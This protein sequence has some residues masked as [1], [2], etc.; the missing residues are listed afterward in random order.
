MISLNTDNTCTQHGVRAGEGAECIVRG[1]VTGRTERVDPGKAAESD[2]ATIAALIAQCDS[3]A[4]MGDRHKALDLLIRTAQ[5]LT[6]ATSA[7][8]AWLQDGK[9]MCLGRCGETAPDLGAQLDV[10]SGLS[11]ECVQTGRL[12]RCDDAVADPRVHSGFHR[13]LGLKSVL[14]LPLI[15]EGKVKGVVEVF[16]PEPKAFGEAE[17]IAL[18]LLTDLMV[19][20]LSGQ[21]GER[22]PV[23]SAVSAGDALVQKLPAVQKIPAVRGTAVTLDKAESPEPEECRHCLF[24]NPVG[25]PFCGR[26]GVPLKSDKAVA[27]VA[28]P[29]AAASESSSSISSEVLKVLDA[30]K[31]EPM[32]SSPVSAEQIAN[33][34]W[35]RLSRNIIAG[36]DGVARP[37]QT[38]HSVSEPPVAV[39]NVLP[40]LPSPNP[41]PP[42]AKRPHASDNRAYFPGRITKW[43]RS[44]AG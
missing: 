14:A 10:S 27:S 31:H 6:R 28:A 29:A 2:A 40:E 42:S 33:V 24:P 8:V 22:K 16:S 38:I 25:T 1:D 11:G 41:Q 37:N 12:V 7:A 9:M 18:Q 3:V 39:N 20:I 19:E 43:L 32:E 35:E 15:R 21:T 5:Q 34:S 36:F 13:I 30:Q 23:A 26:C 4:V 17:A 44:V